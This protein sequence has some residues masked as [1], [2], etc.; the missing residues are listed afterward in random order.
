M[1]Y[2][3]CKVLLWLLDC[4][5]VSV[6]GLRPLKDSA[7]EVC[8]G[9]SFTDL[10]NLQ[11]LLNVSV[12]PLE[13]FLVVSPDVL[14]SRHVFLSYFS[15][16]QRI[17]GYVR[18]WRI[19]VVHPP[20]TGRRRSIWRSLQTGTDFVQ[21]CDVISLQTLNWDGFRFSGRFKND[22]HQKLWH[23]RKDSEG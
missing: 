15:G 10:V 3:D 18:P 19:V 22:T 7:S 17:L 16:A 14:P 6:Q 23:R 9:E 13:N 1:H 12:C 8:E 4:C 5:C 2:R 20:E 11:P 21:R